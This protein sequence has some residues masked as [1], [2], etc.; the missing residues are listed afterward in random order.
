MIKGKR[1]G[2]TDFEDKVYSVVIGIPRGQVRSYK[3]VAA[4]IGRPGAYRAVGS[5]LKRN[6]HMGLVPCHRVVRSDG[7][8]GGFVK[9]VREK[10]RLLKAEGVDLARRRDV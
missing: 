4:R 7:R 2:K 6:P 5:A 10:A 8:P 9:G 3:W 1:L